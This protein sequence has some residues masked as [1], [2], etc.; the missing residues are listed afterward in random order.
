MNVFSEFLNIMG[1]FVIPIIIVCLLL[2]IINIVKDYCKYGNKIF[3]AF[4]KY[5]D[6]GNLKDI[7]IN[8][9]EQE[10]LKKPII[11][12]PNNVSFIALTAKEIYGI[13][14]IEFDG[15]LSGKVTDE[16]LTTN[17][18]EKKFLNPLCKFTEDL[19]LLKKK[20]IDVHPLIIKIGR[21][22]ELNL[23][24]LP[25]SRVMTIKEFSYYIYKNQHSDSKYS[26][27][28]LKKYSKVVG[29]IVNGHN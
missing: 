1:R 18:T 10:C 9:L 17:G 24:D 28:V 29:K 5:E 7:I 6:T 15:R 25:S 13:A 27:D 11:L 8:I 14:I 4:K 22:I 12:S 23:K 16:Y 2:T 20:G 19:K 21:N 26:E 3:S